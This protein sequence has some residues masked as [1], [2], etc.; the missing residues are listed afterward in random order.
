M[1][2]SSRIYQRPDAIALRVA[3]GVRPS[4]HPFGSSH[5]SRT[6]E[7]VAPRI[8]YGVGLSPTRIISLSLHFDL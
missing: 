4:L 2:A 7:A 6:R 3:Y 8:A 1:F 5:I